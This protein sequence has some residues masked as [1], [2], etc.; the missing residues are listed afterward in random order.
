MDPVLV[1]SAVIAAGL[2][3]AAGAAVLVARSALRGTDS[4]HRAAVLSAVAEVVRAVRG[5]R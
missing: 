4:Q 2:V 5:K 3:V 1:W